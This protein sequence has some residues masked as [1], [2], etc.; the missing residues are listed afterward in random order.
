M[1]D[2]TI[3][4]ITLGS[5]VICVSPLTDKDIYSLDLA[6]GADIVE[7]R[8]DMFSDISIK[9]IAHA[10]IEARKKFI[11]PIIATCRSSSE[12]GAVTISDNQRIN[13]YNAVIEAADAIDIELNSVI[14]KDIIDLAIKHNKTTIASFHD[15]NQTP[16][17]SALEKIYQMGRTLHC[18]IVKIAVTPNNYSD[19]RTL[20]DFTLK[21]HDKG[22]V[23]IAIG[24][25][26]RTGRLFLPLIGSLFTFASI[27]TSSA[28][29]QLTIKEFRQF[30]P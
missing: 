10:F 6:Y 16:T 9:G 5:K 12:G 2:I 15:F 24:E 8:I 19:L 28:P 29:G 22:I 7:L 26:G 23:T 13:I 3:G 18:D 4:N 25:L 27:K 14:A 20:T 11:L 21:Y 17:L 30:F 1:K